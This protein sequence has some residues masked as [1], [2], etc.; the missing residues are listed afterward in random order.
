MNKS[1][2]KCSQ[3]RL[4]GQ[5]A[6]EPS[7]GREFQAKFHRGG[8]SQALWGPQCDLCAGG[9][10]TTSPTGAVGE[11]F[12]ASRVKNKAGINSCI[13]MS[14]VLRPQSRHAVIFVLINLLINK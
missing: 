6:G 4:A 2:R 7:L 5:P 1:L 10:K 3:G 13:Y 14:P 9:L 11:W 12:A 8:P